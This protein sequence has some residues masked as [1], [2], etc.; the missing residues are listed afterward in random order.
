MKRDYRLFIEDIM[1]CIEKIEQFVGDLSFDEFV[2]DDKTSSAVVRKLEIIGEATKNIPMYIREKYE[3][4][5]WNDMA[6]MRDKIIHA[7]FGINYKIIWNVIKERLPEI[8]PTIRQILKEIK[9]G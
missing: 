8:K 5:P 6:K 9:N 4:L 2:K 3:G 1:D 7:Y